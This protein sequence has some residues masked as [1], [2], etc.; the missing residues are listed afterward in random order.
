MQE[1]NLKMKTIT[2]TAFRKE[3]KKMLDLVTGSFETLIIPRNNGEDEGVVIMPLSE[4]NSL[5]E[6]NYLTA[7]SNNKKRLEQAIDDVKKGNT[8]TVEI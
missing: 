5:I 6:T 8:V 1:I 2:S 7:S 3:M 4:Y